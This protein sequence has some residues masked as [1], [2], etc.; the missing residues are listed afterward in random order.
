MRQ[1]GSKFYAGDNVGTGR[2]FTLF[3]K[4]DSNKIASP[5][6][7]AAKQTSKNLEAKKSA[8]LKS[9]EVK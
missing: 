6:A 5:K 4:A 9:K 8:G 1:V 7:Q 3:A 2:D